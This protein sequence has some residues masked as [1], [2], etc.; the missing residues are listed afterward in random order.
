MAVEMY[1][2]SPSASRYVTACTV[3]LAACAP[4]VA[5]EL[6]VTV[7]Q[8]NGRGFEDAVVIAEPA[9]PAPRPRA[10]LKA[11]MD[12]RDLMF[13]P[14]ILV[15]RTGT[16]VDFPNSDQVRHQV[17]SFSG[18]KT[19]QLS[20]Y[21]GST[22][23]PVVFDKPGL[24]TLG[25]NIHDGMIGYIYVTDSPWFGR[26]DTKGVLLLHELPPGEYTLQVWHS[27]INDAPAQLQQRVTV[28]A[29]GTTT[30]SFHL[31][32]PLKAAMH[33]HGAAKKWQDY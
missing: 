15:V 6:S 32:K 8:D 11:S 17:Y 28:A 14:E 33:N 16:A 24:A 10:P 30:A 3:L 4:V 5:S 19:F 1:V 25:C 21:A 23:P 12:Q 20:L 26:T 2:K 31:L 29:S 18:A 7:Q 22:H 27:R 13:V 9:T